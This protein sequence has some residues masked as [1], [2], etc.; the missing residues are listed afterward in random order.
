MSQGQWEPTL[1]QCLLA[2][3]YSTRGLRDFRIRQWGC[4]TLLL[5]RKDCKSNVRP[6]APQGFCNHLNLA[7]RNRPHFTVRLCV[8]EHRS[9]PL[10]DLAHIV[11]KS[12]RRGNCRLD[13]YSK[14]PYH[15][16][17]Y[18]DPSRRIGTK[19]VVTWSVV[20]NPCKSFICA[21]RSYR[22]RE[23]RRRFA[24]AIQFAPF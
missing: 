8:P 11:Q 21:H 16:A 19:S 1:R 7:R 13:Q 9:V 24:D 23:S 6:T 14:L 20:A 12:L 3:L 15:V 17:E 5:L 4:R 10:A 18:A 22:T 2:K